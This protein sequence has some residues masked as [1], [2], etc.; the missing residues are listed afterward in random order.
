[1]RLRVCPVFFNDLTGVHMTSECLEDLK[2][3]LF[4]QSLGVLA[5]SL[6][7]YPYPSLVGF[8]ASEDLSEIYF[9]TP[10]ATR[11]YANLTRHP[12]ASI[13]IDSRT[14]NPNDFF[15]AAAVTAIGSA[16]ECPASVQAAA[17]AV[18]LSRH[19][20]LTDFATAET[21]AIMRLKVETY[22]LV[23]DFQRVIEWSP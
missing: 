1:M 6:D 4:G 14:H 2:Q 3:L 7:P 8:A 19:P 10:R 18:F 9:M 21:S 17:K 15:N 22:I 13:L 12:Q 11:K 16:E 5:T 20:Q 23:M